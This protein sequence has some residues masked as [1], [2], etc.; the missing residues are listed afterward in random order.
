MGEGKL[1]DM[2]NKNI[3]LKSYLNNF[4]KKTTSSGRNSNKVTVYFCF[5]SVLRPFI[6]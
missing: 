6:H 4:F 3:L 2:Q 5:G 1:V